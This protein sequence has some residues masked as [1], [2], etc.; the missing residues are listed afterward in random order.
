M[1]GRSSRGFEIAALHLTLHDHVAR[2]AVKHRGDGRIARLLHGTHDRQGIIFDEGA[3]RSVLGLIGILGQNDCNRIAHE[4]DAVR[5]QQ[6]LLGILH[7]GIILMRLH[8]QASRIGAGEN[9]CGI[10]ELGER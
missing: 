9:P 7:L 1:R 5:C 2:P 6:R 10:A 3:F 4:A 8:R